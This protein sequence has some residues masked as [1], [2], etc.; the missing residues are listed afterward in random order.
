MQWGHG[1]IITM[2][3]GGMVP[4][5]WYSVWTLI[6][7]LAKCF[8][9]CPQLRGMGAAN[10]N[11]TAVEAKAR[12][13]LLLMGAAPSVAA[14]THDK[15]REFGASVLME[16]EE[17]TYLSATALDLDREPPVEPEV[18]D[19]D[20]TLVDDLVTARQLCPAP[21]ASASAQP[22][23]AEDAM[24]ER[25]DD[26]ARSTGIA[27]LSRQALTYVA[28]YVAAKCVAVDKTLGQVTS[29]ASAIPRDE[30][31]AWIDALSRG[32]LTVPS[33]QWLDQVE[34]LEVTFAAMHGRDIDRGPGI[35]QRLADAAALKFPQLHPR[36]LRK[37]AMT[38]T[39]LRVRELQRLFVNQERLR[40]GERSSSRNAKRARYFLPPEE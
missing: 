33:P 32:G 27:S 5:H 26:P 28:G 39:Q 37:Y 3:W 18:P 31:Y 12:L 8:V 35:V 38:R 30:R 21:A 2:Q 10:T 17:P 34:Q 23:V 19:T 13:R 29:E 14:G 9:I 15:P 1:G 40:R 22:H 36:V 20:V 4:P 11:P 24:L 7:I 16:E 25:T 6:Q